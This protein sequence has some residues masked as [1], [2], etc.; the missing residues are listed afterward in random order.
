MLATVSTSLA[1]NHRQKR[2]VLSC[3]C[4]HLE[5]A[6]T[7]VRAAE[8]QDASLILTLDLTAPLSYTPTYFLGAA[9]LLARQS[10]V[11]IVIEVLIDPNRELVENAFMNG[12]L[13]VTPRLESLSIAEAE[14]FLGWATKLAVAFGSEVIFSATTSALEKKIPDFAHAFPIQAARI[15]GAHLTEDG[16]RVIAE[17]VQDI[18]KNTHL[19]ILADECAVHITD[20]HKLSKTGVAGVT[21]G[22]VL[23][24]AFTAGLRTGLRDRSLYQPARYLKTAN[25][26]VENTIINL[27]DYLKH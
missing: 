2:L 9:L 22:R 18:C 16:N 21:V 20:L 5:I 24:E 10:A 3:R 25:Q 11:P 1:R 17:R 27:L 6:T 8:S 7:A 15:N 19:P 13:V 12:A 4:S 14:A 26:A 23:E